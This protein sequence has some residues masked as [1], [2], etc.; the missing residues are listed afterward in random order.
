MGTVDLLT[1]IALTSIAILSIAGM[2]WAFFNS[3]PMAATSLFNRL[4]IIVAV[5]SAFFSAVSSAIGF[6]LITS[7][8]SADFFRNFVLPPAF[9]VFVFFVG[10]AIWVGGAELVRNRD[11]F[12]GLVRYTG[13]AGFFADMIFFL[14]RS[15]KLFVVIPILA[16][17]LFFISTWTSVVGIAGVDAVRHTYGEELSRLQTECTGIIAYRKNDQLFLDDLNAAARDVARAADRE[18]NSGGQTGLR[19][20]GTT[21]DY[22]N[23]VAQWLSALENS[24]LKIFEENKSQNSPYSERICTERVDG[25]RIMLSRNA[26]ENYDLWVREFETEFEDFR[27]TLNSWRLDQRLQNFLEQQLANFDRANPVPFTQSGRLGELQRGVIESYSKEVT[28]A[29]KSLLRKQKAR[30][31]PIPL[32]SAA[33]KSPER[34]LAIFTTWFKGDEENQAMYH[35]LKPGNQRALGEW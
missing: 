26:F 5:T 23:G 28:D 25:M 10:V 14:E 1:Y 24:A 33:E 30:K 8:E 20:K 35:K 22:I 16:T 9:G 7:Q 27:L 21:T 4:F 12:R 2:V 13:V 11:W 32:P 19:G 34:G 15:L 18:Q 6:G 17:I 31:P 3:K 29:L